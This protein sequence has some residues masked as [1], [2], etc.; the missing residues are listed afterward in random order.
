MKPTNTMPPSINGSRQ[1]G[2]LSVRW[3]LCAAMLGTTISA[4]GI[5]S[6]T[7]QMAERGTYAAQPPRMLGEVLLLSIK[8][9]VPARFVGARFANESWKVLHPFALNE[10]GVYVLDYEVPEG[11]REIRYRVVVDG[12]WIADPENPTVEVD[13]AGNEISV[14]V[15]EKEPVRPIVN[16]RR[17]ADGSLTF[18][19]H[20][21]PGRRVAL[22]A[23]FNNWDPSMSFMDETSPGNYSITLRVS[24]GS[25]W[26]SFFSGGRRILDVRNSE[27][28]VDPD[29]RT[30]SY[31]SNPS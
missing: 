29:G 8:P 24:R 6:L 27:T 18:T 3:L 31:F 9:D 17:E 12:L 7:L 28:A 22:V 5:D 10:N 14:F 26:Y 20:G 21:A 1:R 23:D 13:D 4:F 16:P 2:P 25:H 11:V 19:F 30:V 15:L